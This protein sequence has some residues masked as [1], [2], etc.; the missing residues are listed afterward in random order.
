LL[1]FLLFSKFYTTEYEF[2]IAG[3]SV[4][5]FAKFKNEHKYAYWQLLAK[6]FTL[7]LYI[8]IDEIV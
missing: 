6:H 7:L 5:Y 1:T 2:T 3:I 8:R 4:K